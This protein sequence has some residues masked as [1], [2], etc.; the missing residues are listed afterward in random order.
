L[1]KI[2]INVLENFS[3]Y[4]LNKILTGRYDTVFIFFVKDK[5]LKFWKNGIRENLE[6][7]TLLIFKDTDTVL[8]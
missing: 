2:G 8:Y 6:N 7:H 5:V 1:T 3:N 4:L